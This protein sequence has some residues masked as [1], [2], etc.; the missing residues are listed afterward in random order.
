VAAGQED[1]LPVH[2]G[3]IGALNEARCA[4]RRLPGSSMVAK[5]TKAPD[6]ALQMLKATSYGLASRV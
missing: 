4:F 6:T 2:G 3:P 5:D 1:V